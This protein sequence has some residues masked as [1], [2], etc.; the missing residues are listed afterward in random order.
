MGMIAKLRGLF[1]TKS[2]DVIDTS[3]ALADRKSVV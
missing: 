3:A 2:A 1:G